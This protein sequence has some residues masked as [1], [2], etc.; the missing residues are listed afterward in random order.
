MISRIKDCAFD[1]VLEAQEYDYEEQQKRVGGNTFIQGPIPTWW[2]SAAAKLP[3][4][5]VNIAL[6]ILLA[7]SLQRT[8]A[9]TLYSKYTR[10][11][12]CSRGVKKQALLHMQGAGLV[13]F[14]CKRGRCPRVVP[15]GLSMPGTKITKNERKD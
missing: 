4:K 14:E 11:F 7:R 1:P 9:V 6:A 2:I 13:R 5:T 12:G 3:G 15:L 8:K 10:L